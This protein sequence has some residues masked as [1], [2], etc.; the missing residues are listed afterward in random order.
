ME[1]HVFPR[2]AVAALL[3]RGFVESRH[4]VDVQGT[5][6]PD[7]FAANRKLR[8]QIAVTQATPYYVIV[9]PNTGKKLRETGLS[10]GPGNW[11]ALFIAFL[12]PG[13]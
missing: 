4:H 6:T 10:G 11:E 8:D 9:D 12:Q 2:P 5:L 13:K 7:Q 1:E 3:Q